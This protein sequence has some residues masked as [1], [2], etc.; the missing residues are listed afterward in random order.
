MKKKLLIVG[1]TAVFVT[2][3]FVILS[4]SYTANSSTPGLPHD[5][6]GTATDTAGKPIADGIVVRAMVVNFDGSTENYTKTIVNGTYGYNTRLH[7]DDPDSDNNGRP[8]YF[9]IGELNTSQSYIF[10]SG[11]G[12]FSIPQ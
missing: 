12:K 10:S 7:V 3:I 2:S 1:A 8:I 5:F 11:S 6:Y 9:Y 4:A